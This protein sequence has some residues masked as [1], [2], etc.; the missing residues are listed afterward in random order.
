[1]QLSSLTQY[2]WIKL[3]LIVQDSP[4]LPFQKSLDLISVPMRLYILSNQ[5]KILGLVSYYFTNNLIFN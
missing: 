1:M 3:S 5:L 2:Y 4:L